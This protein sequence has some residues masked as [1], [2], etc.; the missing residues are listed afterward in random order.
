MVHE[1]IVFLLIALLVLAVVISRR[2]HNLERSSAAIILGITK[3]N[4]NRDVQ[5]QNVIAHVHRVNHD[6]KRSSAAIILEVIKQKENSDLQMTTV[7]ALV[8]QVMSLFYD[9]S[10]N[11]H[12]HREENV[13]IF[14]RMLRKLDALLD[15]A[16]QQTTTP[17]SSMDSQEGEVA[18]EAELSSLE[19]DA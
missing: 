10:T 15:Y 19:F 8:H 3:Y 17:E 5:M 14:R 4:E 9:G 18:S 6:V 13:K 12:K 7:I 16:E 2:L 11:Y 1:V